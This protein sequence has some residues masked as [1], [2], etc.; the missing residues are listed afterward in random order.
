MARI[1][2]HCDCNCFF[3]SCEL[4]SHPELRS[5]PVAVCGDPTERHGIILSGAGQGAR[6]L[7]SFDRTRIPLRLPIPTTGIKPYHLSSLSSSLQQC[8]TTH[9]ACA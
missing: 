1:I 9:I 4:L 6:R 3:A 7:I 2:L 5:L 8:D